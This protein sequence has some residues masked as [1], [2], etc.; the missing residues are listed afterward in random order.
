MRLTVIGSGPAAPQPDTPASG[1][2]LQTT[3]TSVLFDCGSGVIARL[4]E[5][6]DPLMLDAVV[7]GHFHADHFIDLAALRYLFPWPGTATGRLTVWLPPGGSS[8]LRALAG[9][10]S[11]RAEFFD[12][13]FD[14]R[15]YETERPIM[16]RDLEIRPAAMHHYVPAW[17]MRIESARGNVVVYG[18]DTG[19]TDDLVRVAR[20][21]D[22]L[23]AEATLATPLEDE[24][25]RGHSTAEEAIAMARQAGVDRLILTHYPSA[26]RQ[27]LRSLAAAAEELAVEPAWPGL[28]LEIRHRSHRPAQSADRDPM[29]SDGAP[30]G[31]PAGSSGAASTE[32]RRALIASPAGSGPSSTSAVRQ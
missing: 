26:R 3:R 29:I 25:S 5:F 16:V 31:S 19:P 21:A 2:L 4:R 27:A 18:G 15:E 22:V 9:T 11:E 23:V 10:M 7:I 20:G 14:V 1:L 8:R 12:D 13:A 24:L 30:D 28:T 17:A 6:A 32:A